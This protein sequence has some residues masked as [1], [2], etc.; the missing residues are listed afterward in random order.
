MSIIPAL[1]DDYLKREGEKND[2]LLPTTDCI[3]T[4]ATSRTDSQISTNMY[5][6]T[7]EKAHKATL[8]TTKKVSSLPLWAKLKHLIYCNQLPVTI[9]SISLAKVISALMTSKSIMTPAYHDHLKDPTKSKLT[10]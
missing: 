6:H 5:I 4:E 7:G 9:K 3:L 1:S 2:L 10:F 8:Y